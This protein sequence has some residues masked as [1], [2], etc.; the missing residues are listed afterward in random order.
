MAMCLATLLA[1]GLG[2]QGVSHFE[3]EARFE[4]PA[5]AGSP[6]AVAVRF[7]PLDPDVRVNE[8]PA[9]R[10]ELAP[11]QSLLV[12]SPGE[13]A[14]T[15]PETDPE[16]PK[17]LDLSEAVRFP[18]DWAGSAVPGAHAVAADVVFFYCSVREGWCRRG[19]TRVEFSVSR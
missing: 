18:V 4:P 1:V 5:K 17:Y 9:P 7:S 14:E 19:K 15:P 6:G 3:L 2:F 13:P 16:E 8:V 11:E 12:A 10:L